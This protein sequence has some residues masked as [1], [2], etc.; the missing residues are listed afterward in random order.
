MDGIESLMMTKD[1]GMMPGTTKKRKDTSLKREKPMESSMTSIAT[2]TSMVTHTALTGIS[3]IMEIT[4][5]NPIKLIVQDQMANSSKRPPK[6]TQMTPKTANLK[7]NK[8]L[9]DSF[10]RFKR[11]K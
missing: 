3:D 7:L 1:P 5:I 6:L 4:Q 2:I 9:L 10:K 11:S 8:A